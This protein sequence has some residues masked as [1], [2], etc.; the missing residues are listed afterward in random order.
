M[1]SAN[2][3]SANFERLN[4]KYYTHECDSDS[5]LC[6]VFWESNCRILVPVPR[7][8]LGL[9]TDVTV[10]PLVTITIWVGTT[11]TTKFL[12]WMR[13]ARNSQTTVLPADVR[14][15]KTFVSLWIL[16]CFPTNEC[17]IE[18]PFQSTIDNSLHKLLWNK[19]IRNKVKIGVQ[20]E[21]IIYR[22]TQWK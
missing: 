2:Y 18:I 10:L 6:R 4:K 19:H 21:Q 1:Y 20:W 8:R 13:R 14:T 22:T 17:C 11:V 16:Y 3:S 7:I 15:M 5:I 12:K 9:G